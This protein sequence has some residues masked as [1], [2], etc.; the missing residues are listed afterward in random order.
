MYQGQGQ[1]PQQRGGYR[2]YG[3]QQRNYNGNRNYGQQRYH[4]RRQDNYYSDQ[5]P[6]QVK[7]K[8]LVEIDENDPEWKAKL[9]LP[10]KDTR[11]QTD[12]VTNT[13]GS[14]FETFGLSRRL[15]MGIFELGFEK[16]SPVQEEAIPLVLMG[17]S[18]LARAKN[19]TGKTGAFAI[20]TLQKVD[21][22][23][24]NIQ[25]L[26][27]LPT[28][29]LALQT[30][31]VYKDLSKHLNLEIV[32]STGGTELKDD[33]IRLRRAVQIVIGTPGRL[34]D[35]ANQGILKI[36][37]C[38]QIVLDEADKLLSADFLPAVTTLLEYM[39]KDRQLLLF[40]ATFP[41]TI[42]SFKEDWMP[43]CKI[44]NLMDELTLKGVSQYY[45]YVNETQK[46]HCLYALLRKLQI[47]QCIIFCNSVNRV[48][49]LSRKITRLGFPTYYIHGQMGQK[50]RNRIFHNFREGECRFLVCTDIFTRGIDIKNLNVVINFDFP[51]S[52]N[53]YLH[54][55]GRSGRFGHLGLAVNFITNENRGN[56]C[57]IETELN[58]EIMA[59]PS[60]IDTKLYT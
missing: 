15:L 59:I 10:T 16:P 50:H 36:Q 60:K 1:Q 12:D 11:Q 58:T 2:D 32:T 27:L 43:D 19:G 44:L 14:D 3:Y 23:D 30:A 46:V 35:L 51:R 18:L 52:A 28:R 26:V 8:K 22:N 4:G 17:K 13:K 42:K 21:P 9:T 48:E 25:V 31:K 20:P 33:I 45:A 41:S 55:I 5:A 47:N 53:T 29:E 24:Q 54:R 49:L 7:P 37:Q 34:Q 6:P 56:L 40:S 39:P 38:K 57:K